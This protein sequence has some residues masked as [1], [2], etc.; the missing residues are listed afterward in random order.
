MGT[1][2]KRKAIGL[3]RAI[4]ADSLGRA[5]EARYP[6]AK[7]RAKALE[8]DSGVTDSTINRWLACEVSPNLDQ[9]EFVARALKIMAHQLLM[10]YLGAKVGSEEDPTSRPSGTPKTNRP[11]STR[12][13]EH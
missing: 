8:K 6:D 10:P 2:K 12:P 3:L 9:V 7:N 5:M 11:P 1:T 4:F 13:P